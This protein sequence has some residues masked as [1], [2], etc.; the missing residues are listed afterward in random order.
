MADYC[1]IVKSG[2]MMREF[3]ATVTIPVGFKVIG[4]GADPRYPYTNYI[5][6]D[7]GSIETHIEE[8]S[9]PSVI[10]VPDSQDPTQ[11]QELHCQS[12][13]R[14]IRLDGPLFYS[15]VVSGFMPVVPTEPESHTHVVVTVPTAFNTNNTIQIM[16]AIG[17]TCYECQLPPEILADYKL[18]I[19]QRD[20]FIVTNS[21]NIVFH[22]AEAPEEF[23]AELNGKNTVTI[24]YPL[25]LILTPLDSPTI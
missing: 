9:F 5:S 14:V 7:R 25:C 15:L 20:E 10:Y 3:V 1:T 18:E 19:I 11:T 8:K 13:A 23:F 16:D 12:K 21:G 2:Q 4:D 17:Y 24:N 6:L 22:R